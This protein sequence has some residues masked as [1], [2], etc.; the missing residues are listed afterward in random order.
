MLQRK[1]SLEMLSLCQLNSTLKC[2]RNFKMSM[3]NLERGVYYLQKWITCK[4]TAQQS[5]GMSC[6]TV[7]RLWKEDPWIDPLHISPELLFF[8]LFCFSH[9]A[10]QFVGS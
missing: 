2:I 6:R 3:F 1:V 8:P 9:I 5:G 4:A 10:I 7:L